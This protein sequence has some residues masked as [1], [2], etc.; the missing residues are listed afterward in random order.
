[1]SRAYAHAILVRSEP[2]DNSILS[3]SP[4]EIRMWFNETIVVKFSSVKIQDQNGNSVPD[5]IIQ[6]DENDRTLMIVSLPELPQGIYTVY[7]NTYSASD[8]HIARGF[9]VFGLGETSVMSANRQEDTGIFPVENFAEIGLR[10]LNFLGLILT[11]GCFG[12]LILLFRI[13]PVED[14]IASEVESIM[15]LARPRVYFMGM[16]AS[17]ITLLT[18]F[19]QLAWQTISSG[20]SGTGE[21]SFLETSQ[22]ILR[23]TQW[24]YA[25]IIRQILLGLLLIL[26]MRL[27]KAK[28][29]GILALVLGLI[30]AISVQAAVSFVSH[31][32]SSDNAV[33]SIA[34]NTVHLV[35]VGL[36]VG[37][38]LT[39]MFCLLV[40]ILAKKVVFKDV[41]QVFWGSFSWL[42][43]VSVGMVLATGIYSTGME[44]ASLDGLVLSSYGKVLLVKILLVMAVGLVGAVNSILLHPVL[45]SPLASL[46]HKPKGWTPFRLAKFPKLVLIEGILGLMVILSVGILTTL[47]PARDPQYLIP[48]DAQTDD[49]FQLA[50][51][52]TIILSIRPNRPGQNLFDVNVMDSRRPPPAQTLK[53]IIRTTYLE[54]DIGTQSYDLNFFEADGWVNTYRLVGNYLVQPGLWQIEVVVRRKGI[55]DSKAIFHW[56]VLPPG[57]LRPTVLSRNAWQHSLIFL[58]SM[59]ALMVLV[60]AALSVLRK[61]YFIFRKPNINK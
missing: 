33:I 39:L 23:N 52:L 45:A 47:P 21:A 22:Y 12:A 7:W 37:T 48:P 4:A 35:F 43:A 42:A 41:L 10:W 36:W 55:P 32:A 51:D 56:T 61:E 14:R 26:F 49:E 17:G 11:T 19:T 59:I 3:E 15:L 31:A 5:L 30:L 53:V 24:G 40:P 38:L 29:P 44:V 46:F 34:V 50:D 20:G 1:M 6:G 58:A 25:L 54:Q 57:N 60:L 27:L 13:K 18:G 16:F 8:G 28:N 2:A 9:I